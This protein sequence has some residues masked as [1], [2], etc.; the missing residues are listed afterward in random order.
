MEVS[1]KFANCR[2]KQGLPLI[3]RDPGVIV[4][5]S[6]GRKIETMKS[7]SDVE[8]AV[9]LVLRSTIARNFMWEADRTQIEERFDFSYHFP[10]GCCY[11]RWYNCQSQK[12]QRNVRACVLAGHRLT[13]LKLLFALWWAAQFTP[14]TTSS[15]HAPLPDEEPFGRKLADT[16]R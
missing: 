7:L 14:A 1:S 3:P 15:A 5:C 13:K 11:T 2:L 9:Q 4:S 12:W 10:A 16:I 6:C 8:N